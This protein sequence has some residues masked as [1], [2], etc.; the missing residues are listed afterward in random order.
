MMRFKTQSLVLLALFFLS[1]ESVSD[2]QSAIN[3]LDTTS[4]YAVQETE[5]IFDVLSYYPNETQFSLAIIDSS[6][7]H[8]YGAKRSS[9]SLITIENKGSIF[10]I[11]SITKVFTSSVLAHEVVLNG[12]DPDGSVSSVLDFELKDDINFT[13]KQLANHTSGLPRVP[14]G[15]IWNAIFSADNPY[16]NFDEDKLKTYLSKEVELEYTPGSDHSYSNLGAGFLGYVL[17]RA[18][19]QT[20]EELLSEHI[21]MPLNM[22]NSTTD[23]QNISNNL[24][25]G[26]NRRG[27]E[28]TNWDLGSLVS[29]GGIYSSTED[30]V[31][32]AKAQIDSTSEVYN[33]QKEPTYTISEDQKIALGWFVITREDGS[34]IYWHNGGTG[35]YRSSMA[36]NPVNGT[37][38]IVLSNISAGHSKASLIDRLSFDLLRLADGLSSIERD[39]NPDS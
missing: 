15:F 39:S 34:D 25:K 38:V 17:E 6:G 8:Y 16:K 13:Y 19:G 29:A 24:V 31:K 5:L 26:V 36:I 18:T 20:Y 22:S 33:Y 1:C 7:T 23:R 32:Y 14:G 3:E 21:F 11:G 10:E 12:L 28:A 35:G 27:G 30:L 4:Y 2:P 37:A 9:D